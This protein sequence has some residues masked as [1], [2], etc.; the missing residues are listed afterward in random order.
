MNIML[1]P[2]KLDATIHFTRTRLTSSTSFAA[3]TASFRQG[4]IFQEKG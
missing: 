4:A 3:F 2:L 1:R